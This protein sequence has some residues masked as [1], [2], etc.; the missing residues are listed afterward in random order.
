MIRRVSGLACLLL[1][2][3][4]S[5]VV[6]SPSQ[7]VV[8]EPYSPAESIFTVAT[9]DGFCSDDEVSVTRA[10]WELSEGLTITKV[11]VAARRPSDD[12]TPRPLSEL[13]SPTSSVLP[14]CDGSEGAV[15]IEVE[16]TTDEMAWGSGLTIETSAGEATGRTAIGFCPETPEGMGC[17]EEQHL[18]IPVP[19]QD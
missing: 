17:T 12:F 16:I 4:S 15:V 7:V 9:Q 18:D 3:C 2:G 6:V 1:A 5:T 13:G 11:G 10:R 8:T 14:R 19:S